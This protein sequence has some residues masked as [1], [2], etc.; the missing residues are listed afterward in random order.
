MVVDIWGDPNCGQYVF[1]FQS[2]S[3]YT[4]ENEQLCPNFVLIVKENN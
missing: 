1:H 3:D 2:F 4:E